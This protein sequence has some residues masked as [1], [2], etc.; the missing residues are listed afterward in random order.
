[1]LTI[2]ALVRR[3]GLELPD[4]RIQLYQ[5]VTEI[6]LTKWFRIRSLTG[7]ARPPRLPLRFEDA[8]YIFGP[9][10]LW[11]HESFPGGIAPEDAIRDKLTAICRDRRLRPES[12]YAEDLLES[13]RHDIGLLVERGPGLYAFLHL[14]F[15]EYFAAYEIVRTHRLSAYLRQHA[16]EPRWEETLLLG[17]DELGID[18]GDG[19]AADGVVEEALALEC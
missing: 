6:L 11:M 3:R 7:E 9:L 16:S 1:M 10:A 4:R 2:L 14:T 5:H 15:Q 18:R 12:Q 8:R 13:A 19:T 17:A